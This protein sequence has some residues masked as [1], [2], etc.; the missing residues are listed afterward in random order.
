MYK[1]VMGIVW[2]TLIGVQAIDECGSWHGCPD[3]KHEGEGW[4]PLM[5]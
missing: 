3:M 2:M 4:A 1:V 5:Q